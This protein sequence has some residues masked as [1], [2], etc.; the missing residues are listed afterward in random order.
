MPLSTVSRTGLLLTPSVALL[1]ASLVPSHGLPLAAC[2]RPGTSWASRHVHG[3]AYA[4]PH[5]DTHRTVLRRLAAARGCPASLPASLRASSC[6]L[7]AA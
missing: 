1:I 4:P 2:I 5:S 7:C 3:L 6:W